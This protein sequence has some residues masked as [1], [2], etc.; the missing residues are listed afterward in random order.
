MRAAESSHVIVW[1][2]RDAKTSLTLLH[3]CQHSCCRSRNLLAESKGICEKKHPFC[4]EPREVLSHGEAARISATILG[5]RWRG[6]MSTH[7]CRRWG[8]EGENKE[9]VSANAYCKWEVALRRLFEKYET[10]W[11][12]KNVSQDFNFLLRQNHVLQDDNEIFLGFFNT[13][14]L[15]KKVIYVSE[16]LTKLTHQSCSP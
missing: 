7:F 10:S 6:T 15:G 9:D 3:L 14:K 11:I 13:R 1:C 8:G 5:S 12:K 2:E 4:S 16:L